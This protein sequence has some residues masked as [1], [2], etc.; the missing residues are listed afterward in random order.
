MANTLILNVD[1]LW[2][3]GKNRPQYFKAI[4]NHFKQVIKEY[5][6]SDFTLENEEQ[7][8]VAKSQEDFS[9]ELVTALLKVPG[10]NSL[11]PAQRIGVDFD[12]IMPALIAR[13][14]DIPAPASFK[15]E[16]YRPYKK[17]PMRSLDVSREIGHL[18]LQEFP[19]WKVNVHKP[20]M[21]VEIRIL[22]K[23]IYLS[24]GQLPGIGGQPW[25]MSGHAISLLSG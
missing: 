13:L 8:L 11:I 6:Q 3:K 25:G 20:A 16:T 10:L 18:L 4:K 17:F 15:V 22:E 2:L 19:H 21:K 5:H 23:N 24:T 12:Q 9:D 14:K 1:E 7:R